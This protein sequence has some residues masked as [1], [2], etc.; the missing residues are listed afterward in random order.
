M[1]VK[2]NSKIIAIVTA[3][4]LAFV[5]WPQI[6]AGQAYAEEG[7]ASGGTV[8]SSSANQA[9]SAFGSSNASASYNASTLTITLN[10][11]VNLSAPVVFKQGNAEDTVVLDLS[12]HTLKGA[13]GTALETRETATGKDAIQIIPGQFN[14]EIKG[15]GSVVGGSGAVSK[16]DSNFRRGQSGG[17]AITFVAGDGGAFWYPEATGSRKL[18]YGLKVTGGAAVKGGAGA[19][20][21]GDDWVNNI[22]HCE[23]FAVTAGEGGAGIGQADTA[24]EFG[25]STLAYS[26][27]EIVSGTV[28]GGAGG[29]LDMGTDA[30]PILTHYNMMNNS[31]IGAFM[32]D[33]PA[34]YYDTDVAGAIKLIPGTG[35][36]GIM[37]GAGRKYLC[38]EQGT[39]VS[40]GACGS[41]DYGKSKFVNRVANEQASA[42]NGISVYGDVGLTN[43]N[44]DADTF[45]SSWSSR[46]K[47]SND[48]GIYIA[49]SVK[50]GNSPDADAVKECTGKGGTGL[51]MQGNERYFQHENESGRIVTID[52]PATEDPFNWGIVE[53][54]GSGSVIGGSAGTAVCGPAGTGGIGLDEA[55][56]KNTSGD[57]GTSKYGTDYYIINGT[58][59]GGRGGDSLGVLS[60]SGSCG[61]GGIGLCTGNYRE[62]AVLVGNGTLTGGDSGD[63]VDR[64]DNDLQET[65]AEGI[66]FY[67]TNPEYYNNTV[68]VSVAEGGS[69]QPISVNNNGLSVA[70]TMSSFADYPS[71]STRLTCTVDKPSGYT[72]DIYVKWTAELTLQQNTPDVCDIE[73]PA[74]NITDFNLLSD[75]QYKYLLASSGYLN[76]YNLNIATTDRI[77]NIIRNNNSTCK[78]WC[79]VQLEDGR[80]AESE[81]MTFT[82][83][84]WSGGGS[85]PQVDPAEQEAAVR[86]VMAMIDALYEND[87]SEISR[88]DEPAITAARVAYDE[89]VDEDNPFLYLIDETILQKLTAAEDRL[90]W[91]TD[92]DDAVEQIVGLLDVLENTQTDEEL[93]DEDFDAMIADAQSDIEGVRDIYD[94]LAEDQ[95]ALISSYAEMLEAAEALMDIDNNADYQAALAEFLSDYGIADISDAEISVAGAKYTGLMLFPKVTV[96]YGGKELTED[97]DFTAQYENN[98]NAG[99]A[100]VTITG[101]GRFT[102]DKT[103]NFEI[104]KAANTLSVKAKTG[105]VR[106]KYLKKRNQYLAV[107]KVITFND[108][109]Q[110]ALTYKKLKGTK[111]ITIGKTTGKVTVKKKLKRKTYSVKVRITAEGDENHEPVS[112]IIT[113]KVKVK[114]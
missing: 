97:V 28:T 32:Q 101:M 89:L 61:N 7:N 56:T 26:K 100:S 3:L 99:P 90:D 18:N 1:K 42:G 65:A 5:M 77:E 34:N 9:L 4:L 107:T 109:G 103:S 74:A 88:H 6:G 63:A 37:I 82:K 29:S 108:P 40:G 49:G 62:N 25:A 76:D 21:T 79:D 114:K 102:G 83:D 93:S 13:A 59:K 104:A 71:T 67:P 16:N 41:V 91:F 86:N 39:E 112:K 73:P 110:G 15:S 46:D 57:L 85:E 23:E 31:A 11:D 36:D 72:G 14:I 81:P 64:G 98:I 35:G 19:D 47:N 113:F 66:R 68:N 20:I 106:Y 105:S 78:I 48:M 33:R 58:V 27:I 80:W 75:E 24:I 22:S 92:I 94:D 44:V 45:A 10:K 8:S 111:K 17:N 43:E 2:T 84:G 50:G 52:F 55:Y 12:G 95:Q 96:T 30:T 38:V 69:A 53:V 51:M 87:S 70:T 54:A 60:G